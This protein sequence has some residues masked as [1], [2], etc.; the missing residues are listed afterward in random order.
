TEISAGSFTM[1]SDKN[2][3]S[4]AHDDEVPRHQ[5]TLPAFF[6]GRYEVTVG[7]YKAC[8]NDGVCRPANPKAIVGRD[9]LPVRYVSWHEAVAYCGWL[10]LKLK[11]WSGA[12][13]PL[14]GALG[15]RRDGRPW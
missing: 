3:D 10:E 13:G 7:Q 12:P 1:G 5:V 2:K 11:S 14:A 6:I 4:Q 8:V 15:G 9:D